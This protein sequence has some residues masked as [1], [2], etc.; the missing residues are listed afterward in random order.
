M[1][2]AKSTL[3]KPVLGLGRTAC[4]VRGFAFSPWHGPHK[5]SALVKE[6]VP[7]HGGVE[8]CSAME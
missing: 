3:H 8:T 2:P 6:E 4:G 7:L 5:G 1:A